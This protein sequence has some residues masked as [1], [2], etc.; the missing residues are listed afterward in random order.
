MLSIRTRAL[1]ERSR[2]WI[3][4]SIP[5]EAPS[6]RNTTCLRRALG[7]AY[8]LNNDTVIRGG[9]G[10]S[11]LPP[12]LTGELATNSLVNAASTQINV[13]GALPTP[14]QV[15]VPRDTQSTHR[16]HRSELHDPV[17]LHR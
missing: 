3:P 17:L 5:T 7:F 2:L 9:Y 14:L 6:F 8:R 11:Y 10:I 15:S 4:L 16:A 13:T 12:D 1:L